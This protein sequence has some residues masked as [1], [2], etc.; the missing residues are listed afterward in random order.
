MTLM[1]G[2]DQ[3][4]RQCECLHMP[5]NNIALLLTWS[6]RAAGQSREIPSEWARSDDASELYRSLIKDL[7]YPQPME[8]LALTLSA[9]LA[10]R[11]LASY[12]PTDTVYPLN[13]CYLADLHAIISGNSL[14]NDRMVLEKMG[15]SFL[16]VLDTL[17]KY[18]RVAGLLAVDP[19]E[20]YLL[21]GFDG[22][23]DQ[24][25]ARRVTGQESHGRAMRAVGVLTIM[26]KL[27]RFEMDIEFSIDRSE[28]DYCIINK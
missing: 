4:Y 28:E 6:P 8:Q 20:I 3:T 21:K 22:F 7:L 1:R 11:R 10:H 2:S 27:S 17:K 24:Y 9:L 19:R 18:K 16:R 23:M 5:N 12:K 25:L 14:S 26:E 15:F 13:I